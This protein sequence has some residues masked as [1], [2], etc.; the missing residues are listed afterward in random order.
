MALDLSVVPC[1]VC[2][3]QRGQA[4]LAAEESTQ[5]FGRRLAAWMRGTTPRP[6]RFYLALLVGAILL[7]IC[8]FSLVLVDRNARVQRENLTLLAG[9]TAGSISQAV[10][11]ELNGMLTTMR[12]LASSTSLAAQDYSGFI[13][14]RGQRWMEAVRT[15]FSSIGQISSFSTRASITERRSARHPTPPRRRP[16]DGTA[17][18]SSPM[19]SSDAPPSAGCSTSFCRWSRVRRSNCSS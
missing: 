2:S 5:T 7:P 19:S 6:V 14:G 9:A 11:Q 18:L 8:V 13:N 4:T 3:R 1:E 10:D 12:V 17:R 16:P 15:P